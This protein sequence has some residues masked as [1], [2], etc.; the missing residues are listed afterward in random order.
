MGIVVVPEYGSD[1]ATIN[2][3]NL[4]LKV[5]GLATEFNG[6]IDNDNIDG[7]AEI[8]NSKLNLTTITQNITHSG[9]L[10]QSGATTQSGTLT[11]SGKDITEA[12]GADIASATTTE[13]YAAD[14]NFMHITGTTTIT[15]L[16]TA[17]QAG[18][19]RTLVFD[20]ALTL[21][22]NGTSLILPTGANITTE[23]GDTAI[24]RAESTANTRVVAYLR[25]TGISIADNAA[26]DAEVLTGTE[27]A[28]YVAPSTLVSHEG[29]I[30]G[31]GAITFSGGTPTLADSFNVTGIADTAEGIVTITWAT[32]FGGVN[33]AVSGSV[34]E[35]DGNS[36]NA[37]ITEYH[38]AR[39]ATVTKLAA[40]D[41]AGNDIDPAI[42]TFMAIGD[43]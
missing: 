28:K 34:G 24:I 40:H 37:F 15:S 22:H 27:A 42:I 33:Y 5:A 8:A 19:S 41:L 43:R 29:V 1:P 10:T 25:K 12:K 7:N 3:A 13:C 21:T 36:P 35:T 11:L 32:D 31:W 14:G 23:A 2:A 4:D 39:T 38:D 26:S 16:G 20:G 18:D 9:T 6:A 17:V 30:K